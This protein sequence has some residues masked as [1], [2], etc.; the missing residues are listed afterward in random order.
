MDSRRSGGGA[1]A[2]RRAISSGEVPPIA[3][4]P[5]SISNATAASA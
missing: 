5:L 1:V 2:T 4:R 3:L